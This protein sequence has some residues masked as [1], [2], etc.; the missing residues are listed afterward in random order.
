[1]WER[2]ISPRLAIQVLVMAPPSLMHR[3]TWK[4]HVEYPQGKSF[5][6]Q[7]SNPEVCTF[8]SLLLQVNNSLVPRHVTESWGGGLVNNVHI[9]FSTAILP[10]LHP[11]FMHILLEYAS[12]NY[13]GKGQ[14][15]ILLLPCRLLLFH[16]SN[17]SSKRRLGCC[18]EN[19]PC[20]ATIGKSMQNPI[21][22]TFK[23]ST[24]HQ[25]TTR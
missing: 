5:A 2:A 7:V 8:P 22:G 3:P 16:H 20:I 1:M 19:K 13:G 11:S 4:L 6:L 23:T 18:P 25:M 24:T 9:A 12:E 14:Q 17:I 21:P 10:R 15:I